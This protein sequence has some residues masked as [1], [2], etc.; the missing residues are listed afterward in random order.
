[1]L[2]ISSLPL[3]SKIILITGFAIGFVSFI[4]VMRYPIILILMKLSPGYRAYIKKELQRSKAK[5]YKSR[6]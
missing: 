2:D 3:F 1:M 5:K 4:L 6:S